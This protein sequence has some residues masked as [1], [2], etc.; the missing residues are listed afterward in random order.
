[1]NGMMYSPD[2]ETPLR[3]KYCAPSTRVVD[4]KCDLSFLVSS[5]FDGDIEPTDEDDLF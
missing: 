5:N 2:N 4:L 3:G 1:M